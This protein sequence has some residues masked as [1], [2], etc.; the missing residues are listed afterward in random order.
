LLLEVLSAVPIGGQV[1]LALTIIQAIANKG[2]GADKLASLSAQGFK[3]AG[4]G[5]VD[6]LTG[7][8]VR[9]TYED[10]RG[11]TALKAVRGEMTYDERDFHRNSI[12]IS[13]C[14]VFPDVNVP[15]GGRYKVP[16]TNFGAVID[17]TLLAELGGEVAIRRRPDSTRDVPTPD[18]DTRPR[19]CVTLECY[20]GRLEFRSGE[21]VDVKQ[22]G[23][24]EPTGV[25]YYDPTQHLVVEARLTGTGE[26]TRIPPKHLL[27]N[28]KQ[29]GTPTTD[30]VYSCRRTDRLPANSRPAGD[31]GPELPSPR[32]PR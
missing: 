10:G 31:D 32:P 18:G 16:G 4:V 9:I 19:A 13:D 11:V 30:L 25:L 27:Q 29:F 17:P 2:G 7:K 15:V 6:G 3:F 24:F 5:K 1:R 20:D 28:V 8:I 21:R 14:L 23:A 26:F 12:V 22:F